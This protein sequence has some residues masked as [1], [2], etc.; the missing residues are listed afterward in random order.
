VSQSAIQ[1]DHLS[2]RYTIGSQ[3][4]AYN[5]LRETLMNALSAPL[6]N[7]S[8][9]GGQEIWAL[10]EVSFSVSPGE[11]LGI[12]GRN[13]AGKSTLLKIISRITKPTRGSVRLR[14]RVGSLL[15]V[16][17]GFHSE[18]TGRENILLNGAILGMHRQEIKDKFA[19]I[20]EFAE[21][22]PFLDTPVKR[23]SSGMYM[24]LAFAVA[25]HLEPEILLVDE[26]LAVGDAAFQKKCLGKMG[27]VSQ[28]GRTVLFVSHNL[29][30][31]ENLCPRAICLHHGKVVAEG[32]AR[33]VIQAYQRSYREESAAA[34]RWELVDLA[35]GNDKVRL[36]S[37]A[38]APGNGDLNSLSIDQPFK[39]QIEFWSRRPDQ[40]LSI[41][42]HFLT[43]ENILA[44]STSTMHNAD[45]CGHALG[46]GVYRAVCQVPAYL[47]NSGL[48]RL[49]LLVVENQTNVICTLDDAMTFE[50]AP[51][52]QNRGAYFGKRPGIMAPM[53]PWVMTP[54]ENG[55]S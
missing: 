21:I 30:A 38:V 2:K 26:V 54:V 14:G 48:I 43:E 37:L 49:R 23:Y 4:A 55:E 36:R 1:V 9:V 27:E 25:A 8:A 44:F 7:P 50:L 47:L 18:L 40:D 20:V 52:A 19:E 13:G 15:E 22:G 24:R 11:V 35:P 31:L 42:L 16:G 53:L 41:T 17:T 5:T 10:N 51:S 34:R 33:Q 6:R 28:Q 3:G 39:I 32:N 45:L 46:A 29:V 12:I